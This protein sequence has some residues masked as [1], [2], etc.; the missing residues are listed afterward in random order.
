MRTPISHLLALCVAFIAGCG[1]GYEIPNIPVKC[2][3]KNLSDSDMKAW[4]KKV[5]AQ[6]TITTFN[7]RTY[8]E[9]KG[10]GISLQFNKSD[11]LT[12][13]FAY[14]DK[15]DGFGPYAGKLP[16]GITLQLTRR[17]VE[18]KLGPP[19]RSGGGT[20]NYWSDYTSKGI[21]FTY[22]SMDVNNLDAKI[23]T[24]NFKKP[25]EL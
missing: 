20:I 21:G 6:P 15:A 13:I 9:F 19:E 18:S 3:G 1:P 10:E 14:T 5:Y 4:L 8:Y 24:I 17:E 12:T 7:D 11:V 22:N 2:I 16:Y 25:C 23:Y